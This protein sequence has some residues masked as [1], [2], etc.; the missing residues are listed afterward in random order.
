M[1]L[2]N[3]DWN[4]ETY[5]EFLVYLW[6]EQDKIWDLERHA[7]IL[8]LPS[9]KVIGIRTPII[10]KIAKEIAKRDWRKFV[11]LPINDIYEEKVLKGLVLSYAKENYSVIEPYLLDFY[12]KYVDSWAVC[13]VV[14]GNLKIINKN[15]DKYFLLLKN[16]HKSENPWVVR[17]GLVTLLDYYIEERYL[18]D[19]FKICL[20]V[21]SDEY[22]VKMALAWLISILFVKERDRTL[23]FLNDNRENL[24]PWTY[25]KALQKIIESL[26][27]SSEDKLLMKKMKIKS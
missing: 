17:V 4:N 11:E 16:F 24:D 26:R 13:D 6:S 12:Y 21:R 1:D 22:Y 20:E 10:K 27:V 19:I 2:K 9:N 25:N 8:N 5:K 15:K 14:V 23:E 18:D 3:I 7:K